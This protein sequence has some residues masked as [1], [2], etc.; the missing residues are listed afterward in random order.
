MDPASVDEMMLWSCFVQSYAAREAGKAVAPSSQMA[1]KTGR[2]A[3][4]DEA[5]DR[6]ESGRRHRGRLEMSQTL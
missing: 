5:P 3:G 4:G 6:E 1:K 2:G